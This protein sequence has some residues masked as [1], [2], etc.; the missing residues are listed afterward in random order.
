ME[1][2]LNVN[3]FMPSKEDRNRIV[4]SDSDKSELDWWCRHY[5]DGVGYLSWRMMEYFVAKDAGDTKA[6]KSLETIIRSALPR[7]WEEVI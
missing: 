3:W 7:F 2:E 1:K 4:L 5:K 6:M